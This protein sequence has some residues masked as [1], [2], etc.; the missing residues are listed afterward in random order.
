MTISEHLEWFTASGGNKVDA[1]MKLLIKLEEMGTVTLRAKQKRYQL[2]K[3]G[4]R[5]SIT[6][7]TDPGD[8]IRGELSEIGEVKLEAVKNRSEKSL[9]NEYVD[10]YHYLGYKQPFGCHLRYFIKTGS[11]I[12]G[13]ILLA[14]AAKAL[15]M[16]DKWIGW[17]DSQR[18]RNLAWV[19]NNTRYLIFPWVKIKNLA[20]HVLGQLARYTLKDWE[21]RW[22]YRA[23]LIETF[24]DSRYY[25]GSCYRAA[26]WHYLGNTTG[27]GLARIGKRYSTTPKMIF[28][29]ALD[30]DFRFQLCSDKLTGRVE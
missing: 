15:G 8:D 14:G 18:I 29:K 25:R 10:R 22:G 1:C 26:N 24:V 19:V 28:V 30:K 13:C 23:V 2:R 21:A 5:V 27:E 9:W 16:R 11:R 6:G 17:T 7:R 12:L 20:S 3:Y 4:E